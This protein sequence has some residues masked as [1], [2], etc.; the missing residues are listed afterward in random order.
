MIKEYNLINLDG[1]GRKKKKEAFCYVHT[2]GGDYRPIHF[3]A[4]L[5]RHTLTDSKKLEIKSR[6]L[7]WTTKK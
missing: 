1:L 4:L 6:Q 3:P 5:F 2:A 7:T